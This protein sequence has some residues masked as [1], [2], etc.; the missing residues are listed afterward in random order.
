M[1][2]LFLD[3]SALAKRYLPEQG[4]RW[5]RQQIASANTIIVSRLTL[6]E[7]MSAVARRHREGAINTR[8]MQG[9]NRLLERHFQKQYAVVDVNDKLTREAVRLINTHPLR[10]YDSVQLASALLVNQRLL[11]Q[12]LS[13]ITF[14]CS[15]TRL[16]Q[17]A[18]SEGLVTDDPNNYA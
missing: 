3:T 6:V 4:T 18:T 16:L 15:D 5:L 8:V 2:S 12:K 11:S 7:V 1:S 14:L 13:P 9:I 17:I 10:A